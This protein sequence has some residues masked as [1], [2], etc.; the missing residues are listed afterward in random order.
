VFER[1]VA[2]GLECVGDALTDGHGSI[3][4][5]VGAD[6]S[7]HGVLLDKLER[8]VLQEHGATVDVCRGSV[9]D[10]VYVASRPDEG[11]EATGLPVLEAGLQLIGLKHPLA[12]LL[13]QIL[14]TTRATR[15]WLKARATVDDPMEATPENLADALRVAAGQ[16]PVVCL[17]DGADQL[18]GRWWSTLLLGLVE[19][20]VASLPVVFVL[21]LEDASRPQDHT[22]HE[23]DALFAARELPRDGLAH[24]LVME[25]LEPTRMASITGPADDAVLEALAS[26]TQRRADWA[27]A[28]WD[29]WRSTGVVERDPGPADRPWRFAPGQPEWSGSVRDVVRRE[30][31]HRLPHDL[32]Q[33]RRAHK[34]LTCAA[35]EGRYFTAEVVA[36][37]EQLELDQLIGIFE[38]LRSAD[39]AA[40]VGMIEFAGVRDVMMPGGRWVRVH[41][42]RFASPLTRPA[43]T[44]FADTTDQQKRTIAELVRTLEQ[45]YVRQPRL[46]ASR[47]AELLFRIGNEEAAADRRRVGNEMP[48]EAVIEQA[49]ALLRASDTESWRDER[50]SWAAGILLDAAR[51]SRAEARLD[52]TVAMTA[53]AAQLASQA[54][55]EPYLA[56]ALKLSG[57]TKVYTGRPDDARAELE[58]ALALNG[59][60]GRLGA[61]AEALK[62]LAYLDE[63]ANAPHRAAQRLSE[64]LWIF[65][66]LS[67]PWNML[68]VLYEVATLAVR[69]HDIA[70]AEWADEQMAALDAFA[71]EDFK[72]ARLEQ[73]GRLA[74]MKGQL[75]RAEDFYRQALDAYILL[76]DERSAMVMRR[77]LGAVLVD[78]G[79]FAA[80]RDFLDEALTAAENADN[81]P[82][83]GDVHVS[84]ACCHA[85]TGDLDEAERHAELACQLFA[86]V[87]QPQ[88]VLEAEELLREIRRRKRSG[89]QD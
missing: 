67:E 54:G 63:S 30:L 8:S 51:A 81:L 48:G 23:P 75:E 62:S 87:A 15:S 61:K 57:H 3:V 66:S 45:L 16:R 6:G 18:G 32:K 47:L 53:R 22:A 2:F 59:K 58:R 56:E 74:R 34:A 43:L 65:D 20:I 46:V 28:L 24:R 38:M 70:L 84:L 17:V 55:D 14:T 1:Q 82:G 27:T 37:I 73:R 13:G 52:D 76:E 4:F 71:D 5:V 26:L 19:E 88:R 21:A 86:D 35:L 78:R 25:L 72:P 79:Q 49:R 85:E 29:T 11:A 50:K 33:Q 42:Y 44:R 77:A 39:P 64:A 80:A 36:H 89:R 10:E 69:T 7:G 31:E 83:L 41:R 9:E 40:D 60:L 12:E 68:E